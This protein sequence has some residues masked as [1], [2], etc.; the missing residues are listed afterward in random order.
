MCLNFHPSTVYAYF[1]IC[2]C[3]DKWISIYS[4]HI[5]KDTQR[6]KHYTP[7]LPL[8]NWIIAWERSGFRIHIPAKFKIGNF[9][10]LTSWDWE[11]LQ[12]S[13]GV[14]GEL[15]AGSINSRV[16]HLWKTTISK[17]LCKRTYWWIIFGFLTSIAPYP[18]KL[19]GVT[20]APFSKDKKTCRG[21]TAMHLAVRKSRDGYQ[22]VGLGGIFHSV[23]VESSGQKILIPVNIE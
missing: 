19:V 23:T 18:S 11:I 3:I 14:G 5:G 6:C 22:V 17:K 13:T 16:Y 9:C 7:E 1:S 12:P 2:L 4:I 15:L 21:L 8:K 20:I 10:L